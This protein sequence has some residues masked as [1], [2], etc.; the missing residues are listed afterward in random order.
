MAQKSWPSKLQP[1]LKHLKMQK[2]AIKFARDHA[3]IADACPEYRY[4]E[5][6]ALIRLGPFR[7]V[8]LWRRLFWI[9]FTT[10]DSGNECYTDRWGRFWRK[11]D[12][13]KNDFQRLSL[14]RLSN[15]GQK[16]LIRSVKDRTEDIHRDY[17]QLLPSQPPRPQAG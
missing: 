3:R 15:K 14:E 1:T 4:H 11:S 17:P 8:P 13:A 6:V 9:P 7:L 12:P 2:L 5:R 16:K 10:D